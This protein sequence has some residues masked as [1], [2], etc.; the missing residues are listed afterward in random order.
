MAENGFLL[1]D[2]INIRRSWTS[3]A[4]TDVADSYGQ[5]WVF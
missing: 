5:E 1:S 2:L 3:Q 4:I